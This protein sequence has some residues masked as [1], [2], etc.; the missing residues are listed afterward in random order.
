[1]FNNTEE[2]EI[3]DEL[4]EEKTNNGICIVQSGD[5]LWAIVSDY[6]GYDNDTDIANKINELVEYNHISD[7]NMIYPN[8]VIIM[9]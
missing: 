2:F 4:Q 5:T 1:M 7:A 6:Y 8:Q 9:I 3:K